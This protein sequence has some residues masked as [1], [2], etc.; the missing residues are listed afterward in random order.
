[1]IAGNFQNL[2]HDKAFYKAE[3]VGIRASLNLT[4]EA[5]FILGKKVQ[6]V[7]FGYAV[8]K[9]FLGEIKL[10]PPDDII[11]D[12]PPDFFEISIHLA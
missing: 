5:L 3:H 2:G 1:V 8:R 7:D 6:L 11:V 10:P 4:Q 9:K 12:I